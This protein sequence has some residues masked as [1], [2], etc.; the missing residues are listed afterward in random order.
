MEELERI[1]ERAH[2]AFQAA[3]D[4]AALEN[5]KARF[6]GKS[7]EL[8]AQL[9]GLGA[10]APEA[11]RGA[12]ARINAAKD[13]IERALEAR[14]AQLADSRLQARLAE[15]AIDVT[16]PALDPALVRRLRE[17]FAEDVGLLSQL[18]DRDL[19]HW[20]GRPAPEDAPAEPEAGQALPAGRAPGAGAANP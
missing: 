13:E 1:V 12:G 11:R 14:R 20:L 3:G 10:L 18:L 2:A 6:L 7:G 5:A 16:L 8:T 17:H 15:E 19:S 4:P 9:K